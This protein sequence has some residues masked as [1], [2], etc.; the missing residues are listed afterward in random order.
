M[1]SFKPKPILNRS[2]LKQIKKSRTKLQGKKVITDDVNKLKSLK[3]TPDIGDEEKIN[4]YKEPIWIEYYI[5][6]ESR[7]ALETKYLFIKLVDPI[8]REND[9]ILK[10][11]ISDNKFLDIAEYFEGSDEISIQIQK[12]YQS[13]K[14][15]VFS[16]NDIMARY[17]ITEDPEFLRQAVYLTETL[18]MF[19]PTLATLELLGDFTIHNLHWLIRKLNQSTVEFSLEDRTIMLLIKRRNEYW[20]EHELPEDEEFELFAA[21]FFEQAYPHRG[22]LELSDQDFLL[23]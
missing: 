7:F 2:E 22:A 21:L 16:I 8:P 12:S 14:S 17:K 13:Q 20:E 3:V 11:I 23:D 18:M 6:K 10:K 19:E 4:Y 9:K 5:P 15:I 1:Q